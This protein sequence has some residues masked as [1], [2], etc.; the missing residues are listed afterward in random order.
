MAKIKTQILAVSPQFFK[1]LL[2]PFLAEAPPVGDLASIMHHGV[3][4]DDVES[5]P[6]R[7]TTCRHEIRHLQ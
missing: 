2:S 7:E 4:G 5:F 1:D 6:L 3:T